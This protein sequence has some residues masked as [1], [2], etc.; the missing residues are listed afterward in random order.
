MWL[1]LDMNSYFATCEQQ[2]IP[3]LRGQPVGVAPVMAE[4]TCCIAVSYEAKHAG[5]KTGTKIADARVMCPNIRIVEARPHV[6]R[7]MHKRIKAAVETVVPVHQ[8]LS[9]DEMTIRPWRNERTLAESLRLGQR[10]QDT[11]RTQVGEWM[12]CS[13]GIAPN[14]FLA[15]VASDLH[16]PRGLSVITKEDLPHKLSKLELRDWPGISSGMEARFNAAG[17]Y[18]TLAMYGK[19]L[20]EMRAIFGGI[21]GEYWYRQIHGEEFQAAPTRRSQIGHSSVLS[22]EFRNKLGA[23]AVACRQLEK[24]AE[25]VRAEGFYAGG[26]SITLSS[27]KEEGWSRHTSCKPSSSTACFLKI[28][29]ALWLDHVVVPSKVSVVLYDLVRDDDVTFNLFDRDPENGLDKAIDEVNQEFGRGTLTTAAALQ[30]KE[31]L[32]HQRISFGMPAVDFWGFQ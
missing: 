5:V 22:P 18:T 19:N 9:V 2:E 17:V 30:A 29:K 28:L 32:N 23:W 16:K 31:Y 26:I 11:I 27:F 15:K 8:V 13:I 7:E 21:N 1:F 12:S 24:A 20:V 6:Y 3:E 14:A 4:T 25:R 10:L